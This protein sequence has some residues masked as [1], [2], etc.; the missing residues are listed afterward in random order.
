MVVGHIHL[1]CVGSLTLQEPTHCPQALPHT[2]HVTNQTCS[3]RWAH[4]SSQSLF[5]AQLMFL[6]D[7]HCPCVRGT[8]FLATDR[9][10]VS[11]N[12]N[13]YKLWDRA[14]PG[15]RGSPKPLPPLYAMLP[16]VLLCVP[17]VSPGNGGKLSKSTS[18]DQ[19]NFKKMN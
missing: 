2:G 15:R 6:L 8:S 14:Q 7:S 4:S 18:N 1:V 17:G 12:E 11:L 9:W 19:S 16:S 10:A 3:L 13:V 5:A